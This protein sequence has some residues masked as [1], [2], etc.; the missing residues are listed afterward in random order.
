MNTLKISAISLAITATILAIVYMFVSNIQPAV[1][2]APSGLP[3]TVASTSAPTLTGGTAVG[4]FATSTGCSSR[5]ITTKA[6]YLML[7]FTNKNGQTP[8]GDLGH[9]QAASTTEI[10]DSGLW[11]CGFVKAL[12]NVTQVVTISDVQ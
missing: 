7:T 10:Y 12:S 4:L 1:A 8:T 5:A 2:S 3:A 6:G 11:G 9:Y